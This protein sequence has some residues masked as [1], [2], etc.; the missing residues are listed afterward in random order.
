MKIERKYT[1]EHILRMRVK[2]P[3]PVEYLYCV[4]RLFDRSSHVFETIDAADRAVKSAQWD[5]GNAIW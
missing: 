4:T 5:V 3:N 1:I 2:S